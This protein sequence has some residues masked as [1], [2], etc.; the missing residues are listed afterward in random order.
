MPD[1]DAP[2]DEPAAA[3]AAL[4]RWDV[5][6]G[7]PLRL[8]ALS[9]NATYLVEP[10][11]GPRL[12]LR[13]ARP[14]YRTREEVASEV[15]WVRSLRA[16]GVVRTPAVLPTRDG[17]H[18]AAF[19]YGGRTRLAVLSEHVPGGPPPEA[20]LPQDLER[21]GALAARMHAHARSWPR[22]PGFTRPRWDWSTCLGPDGHWGRWQDGPD[23][24][25]AGRAVLAAAADL[26]RARL[27][28]Y[29]DGP[30]R[31]GLV[32]GDMRRANL[33]APPDHVEHGVVVIDFDDCGESWFLWDA[34]ATLSFLEHR[35]DLPA[36]LAAWVR[37]Y[38][39]EADL[40]A[41]DEAVLPSL[42]LVRR[43]LL[44]AWVGSHA[45]VEQARS[46]RAGF[47]RGTANLARRYL[48]S[49]GATTGARSPR[50]GR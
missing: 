10:P 1:S 32:H 13:L 35:P 4:E 3:A 8:L 2:L 38:R 23:L 42:V 21:L 37:G 33:V 44:L 9:E 26:A 5:T 39:S 7:A 15:A 6:P 29:G 18:V 17:G 46:V 12:V 41:E 36:L 25:D 34:A 40:T 31:F 19:R 22:P 14:G 48:A 45:E 49:G 27:A 24:D 28:A 50:A 47:A 11:G 20:P 43:M 30:D 16:G